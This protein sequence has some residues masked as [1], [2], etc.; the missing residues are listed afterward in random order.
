MNDRIKQHGHSPVAS[1][2]KL[3]F[4][5]SCAAVDNISKNRALWDTFATAEPHSYIGRLLWMALRRIT[6]L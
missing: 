6:T 5:C 1:F 2:L 4:L 3:N